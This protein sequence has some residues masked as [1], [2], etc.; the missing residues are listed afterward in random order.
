MYRSEWFRA[1]TAGFLIPVADKIHAMTCSHKYFLGVR[2]KVVVATLRWKNGV[3]PRRGSVTYLWGCAPSPRAAARCFRLDSA[4]HHFLA[5]SEKP[6]RRF[7]HTVVTPPFAKFL[8]FWFVVA[9]K[10]CF[11]WV[12]FHVEQCLTKIPGKLT[13]D[14]ICP[15]NRGIWD[16][17]CLINGQEE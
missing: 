1:S 9:L 10:T 14:I 8:Q 5:G 16:A 17:K 2:E 4:N 11:E 3:L 13:W 15:R 12:L 7:S 6:K